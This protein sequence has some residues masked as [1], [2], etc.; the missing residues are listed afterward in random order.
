MRIMYYDYSWGDNLV[1]LLNIHFF[2]FIPGRVDGF[3]ASV[4]SPSTYYNLLIPTGSPLVWG[5][6][7]INI[8]NGYNPNTG[9]FINQECSYIP[10]IY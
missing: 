9:N 2:S 4:V 5:I 8:K 3:S 6:V 10:Q 7:H 1:F